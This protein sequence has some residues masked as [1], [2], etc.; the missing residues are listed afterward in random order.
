MLKAMQAY[1]I[2]VQ[3]PNRSGMVAEVT[4]LLYRQGVNLLDSSMS[5]LRGE[6]VMM[7]VVQL[8]ED[9]STEAF[10]NLMDSLRGDGLS[11]SLREL[12][13]SEAGQ[14]SPES[15]PNY[16]L[17]VLGQDQTGMLHRFS[18]LIASYG[19]NLTDV[20]TQLLDGSHS[21]PLYAMI[22]ELHL[23]AHKQAQQAELLKVAISKLAA[24]LDLD[25]DLHPLESLEI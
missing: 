3:G 21:P 23:P 11:L 15:Q 1:L 14:R 22:L 13:A 25:A 9:L 17:S 10:E 2:N 20:H 8:P 5:T 16:S 24:E 18:E 7:L 4:G 6:F 12:S 19:A